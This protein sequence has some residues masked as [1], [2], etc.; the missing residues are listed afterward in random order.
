MMEAEI[1][2]ENKVT[3]VKSFVICKRGMAYLPIQTADIMLFH[4]YATV[5]F[6]IDKNGSKY[7]VDQSLSELEEL[8]APNLFFRVNR[9]LIVNIHS[10]KEFASI[11]CGRIS[12]HL[13]Q[14]DWYKNTVIVSQSNARL[15]REWINS[16]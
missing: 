4:Y 16:L 1:Q 15:F 8:L 3:T 11:E 2:M 10:I 6:A 7:I 5:T 12:I 14:P 13:K 9:Q